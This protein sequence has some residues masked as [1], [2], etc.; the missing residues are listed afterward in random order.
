MSSLPPV[1]IVASARTPVGSFL[2]SL[3]SLTAPQLGSHAIKTAVQ[4]VPAIKPSDVEEVFFGNVL[5]AK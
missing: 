4:R 3:S 2:G 1:Y 5:S